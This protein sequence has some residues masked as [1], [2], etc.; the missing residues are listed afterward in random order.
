MHLFKIFGGNTE[1]LAQRPAGITTAEQA[2]LALEGMALQ[3]ECEAKFARAVKI[4]D[5][6]DV[7]GTYANDELQRLSTKYGIA[8]CPV[9]PGDTATAGDGPTDRDSRSQPTVGPR[10][11]SIRHGPRLQTVARPGQSLHGLWL[12]TRLF[13][14]PCGR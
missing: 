14:L 10:H 8:R 2:C 3:A 7:I 9:H 11:H 5:A 4:R 13:G 1:E 6:L 12:E